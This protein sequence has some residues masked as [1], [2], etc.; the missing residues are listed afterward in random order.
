MRS[1][2]FTP[3]SISTS[4]SATIE[5]IRTWISKCN[6]HHR[7]CRER[8]Q[9]SLY[10]PR[11]LLYVG[12]YDRVQLKESS[13]FLQD[14]PEYVTLS[15]CWGKVEGT[16]LK[17]ANY[18]QFQ[19]GV[20]PA[21]LP[22]TFRDAIDL[23]RRI[24]K[25]YLWIDSLCIIQD[26]IEDWRYESPRM[27]DIYSGAFLNIAANSS[28]NSNGGIYQK[29]SSLCVMP[30]KIKLDWSSL[31]WRQRTVGLWPKRYKDDVLEDT[32]LTTRAWCVQE[33]L[34]ASRT[35]HLLVHKA[36]W[37]CASLHASETDPEGRLESW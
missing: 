2:I 31:G 26:S 17:I 33:R 27:G 30:C 16:K 3:K 19:N 29:R 1:S 25:D 15:H 13:E 7:E 37:E 12:I 10:S 22:R 5:C 14:L 18:G 34:L 8:R 28:W 35:I 4:S 6:E 24:G 11:R 32:P 20:D 9:W 36:V 23:T 21:I